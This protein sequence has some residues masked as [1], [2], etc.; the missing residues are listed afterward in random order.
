[1][2]NR[3]PYIQYLPNKKHKQYGIKKFV[4]CDSIPNY[5]YQIEMYSGTDYLADRGD[6][7]F[8]ERVIFQILEKVIY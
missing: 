8:T 1:M 5:V 3:C 4:C 7:P 2:K 6:T